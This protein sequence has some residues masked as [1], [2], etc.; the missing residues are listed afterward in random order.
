MPSSVS[1]TIAVLEDELCVELFGRSG[2]GAQLTQVGRTFHRDAQAIVAAVDRARETAGSVAS[3]CGGQLR[4][5]IC[6]GATTPTFAAVPAAHREQTS[7]ERRVGT[8]G[9][10]T[11]TNQWEA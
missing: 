11:C 9:G 10:S 3:G 8:A 5:G 4:P 7:E 2:R 6:E 1:R